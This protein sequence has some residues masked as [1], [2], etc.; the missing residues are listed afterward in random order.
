[1]VM[2]CPYCLAIHENRTIKIYDT[3]IENQKVQAHVF[4][5]HSGARLLSLDNKLIL[6]PRTESMFYPNRYR[7]VASNVKNLL[8]TWID[9]IVCELC[10]TYYINNGSCIKEN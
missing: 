1:M 4:E 9:R 7:V 3:T 10:L 5:K 8:R 2:V 6:Y